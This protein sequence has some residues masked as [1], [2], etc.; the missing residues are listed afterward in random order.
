[1]ILNSGLSIFL[2]AERIMTP[3]DFL[4]MPFLFALIIYLFTNIKNRRYADQPLIAKYFIPALTARLIGA[5]LTGLMYRFYY[6][7]GD[8]T[9]YYIAASDIVNAF[10]SKGFDVGLEMLFQQLEDYSYEAKSSITFF[11]NFKTPSMLVVSKF[12]AVLSVFAFG[13]FIGASFGCTI[14][15]FVGCWMLYRVFTD[16]YPHLHKELAY[17]ILFIPSVCFW[18]TGLMKDPLS[19]GGAGMAVYGVY[20]LFYK[21]NK[22]GFFLPFISLLLGVYLSATAKAYVAMALLPACIIWIS[23]MYKNKF[24][25]RFIRMAMGPLLLIVGLFFGQIALF[26]ISKNMSLEKLVDEVN[27]TQ[28][29]ISYSTQRDGGTGYTLSSIEATPMGMLRVAPEAINVTLFRPYLW[30]ARKPVVLIS[31]IESLFTLIFTLY[32]I[33]KLK[34][35]G[36]IGAIYKDSTILFCLIFSIIFAFAVGFTSMNFGALARYK[37]PALPFYFTAMVLLLDRNGKGISQMTYQLSENKYKN[38]ITH[39]GLPPQ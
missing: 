23:L 39:K 11:R 38:T 35:F 36:F 5:I 18:G 14:I 28:W 13:T 17:S 16:I 21:F 25:N 24:E 30:E 7:Y 31:A 26:Q 12:G 32:V 2:F 37:T 9:F 33:I 10:Y 34:I 29:W 3:L 19:I 20:F 15:S 1:M 6:G 27:K 22:K 4:V 8:T